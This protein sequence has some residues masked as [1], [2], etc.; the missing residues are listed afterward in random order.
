MIHLGFIQAFMAKDWIRLE[1][2]AIVLLVFYACV[3]GA[4][5]ID[6]HFGVQKARRRGNV[7]TSYGYR[8][9][10]AKAQSY[11]GLMALMTLVDVIASVVTD[12]P[13]F[14]ALVGIGIILVE[15]KSVFE[16]IR[17]VNKDVE[18]IP[19]ML[20][21]ILKNKDTLQSVISFLNSEVRSKEAAARAG[22][23]EG[24]L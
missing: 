11:F 18:K 24:A 3:L 19:N 4:V 23:E 1:F 13:F 16:N 15:L 6:L 2:L 17:G 5:L 8:Q 10:I 21:E 14:T 20:V 22:R 9:T 7:R 12:L